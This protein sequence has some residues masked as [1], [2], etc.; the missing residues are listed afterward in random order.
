MGAM[1]FFFHCRP[2]AGHWNPSLKPECYP[3]KLFVTFALINTSFNIT[4]DVLF[5]TFPIFIIWPLQMKRK[6]RPYLIGILS[7]GYLYALHSFSTF[8]SN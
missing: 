7:L 4:T 3:M 1:T 6:L 5:A 2:M 8:I